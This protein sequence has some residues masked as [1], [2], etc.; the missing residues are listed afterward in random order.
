MFGIK[1]NLMF[2]LLNNMVEK[3]II[4]KKY[5]EYFKDRATII[6]NTIIEN[7]NKLVQMVSLIIK[8]LDRTYT[9]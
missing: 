2:I 1:T 7:V 4:Q 9:R 5:Y 6:K 8:F 3:C